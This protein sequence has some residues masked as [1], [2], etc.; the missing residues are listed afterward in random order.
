VIHLVMPLAV[1]SP[2]GRQL[3]FR[4]EPKFIGFGVTAGRIAAIAIEK[5][6]QGLAGRRYGVLCE[7]WN[8]RIFACMCSCLPETPQPIR[9]TTGRNVAYVPSADIVLL[10]QFCFRHTLFDQSPNFPIAG[11]GFFCLFGIAGS[12]A[13][14]TAP[15]DSIPDRGP[16]SRTAGAFCHFL[17]DSCRRHSVNLVTLPHVFQFVRFPFHNSLPFVRRPR[18]RCQR[19]RARCE[20][21][22]KY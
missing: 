2:L 5:I 21:A 10:G 1:R 17:R 6:G 12:T 3:G 7:A 13:G 4:A 22:A 9:S 18:H 16:S 14:P 11:G 8:D 15:I 20:Y 19:R